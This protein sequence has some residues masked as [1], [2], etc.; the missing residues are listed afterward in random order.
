MNVIK[1]NKYIADIRAQYSEEQIRTWFKNRTNEELFE[2]VG[3]KAMPVMVLKTAPK[4]IP[5][6]KG[7][8][9]VMGIEK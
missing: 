9:L 2:S 8:E 4:H 6:W 3:Y 1:L 5:V 7:Y